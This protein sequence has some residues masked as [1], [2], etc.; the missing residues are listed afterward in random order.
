MENIKSQ[1][2]QSSKSLQRL[3]VF[4]RYP[5]P[6]KT[7]TRLIDA[8]GKEGAA[9][10]HRQLA[11]HTLRQVK[12][13]VGWVSAR[14]PTLEVYFTGATEAL[15]REWLGDNLVY[16]Q[17]R[18]GDLGARMAQAFDRAFNT[19]AV[20][21]AIIGTDCPS[22]DAKLLLYA[23]E[24]LHST[25]LV[26]GPAAD[27]GYY[28]I[29]LGRMVPELFTGI[30]WGTSR[31]LAQTLAQAQRLNLSLCQLPVLADIDRPS[32]LSSLPSD[33]SGTVL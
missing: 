19:G 30:D 1:T 10:L 13:L 6:G 2:G 7:K 16:H 5:E 8:L 11:K 3:I 28:L 9:N 4:T 17:Q 25:D 23:F 12:S 32:D 14:D 22:I 20:R 24:Q 18:N 27:G 15:M 33:F 26:L 21:V 29:G 31:V